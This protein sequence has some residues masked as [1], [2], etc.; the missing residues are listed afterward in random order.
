VR[1]GEL[2]RGENVAA[3]GPGVVESGQFFHLLR[4]V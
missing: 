1:G 4:V 2:V 3:L